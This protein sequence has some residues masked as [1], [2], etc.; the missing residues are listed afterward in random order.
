[1]TPEEAA[2]PTA[3]MAPL[4]EPAAT[5]PKAPPGALPTTTAEKIAYC[6]R[7]DAKA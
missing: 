6:R 1:L 5:K 4:T 7:V 3:E 2:E